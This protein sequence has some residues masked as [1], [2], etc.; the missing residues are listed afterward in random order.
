VRVPV[1]GSKKVVPDPPHAV[2]GCPGSQFGKRK[3]FTPRA[4]IGTAAPPVRLAEFDG[5][6]ASAIAVA[7]TV[8]AARLQMREKKAG[9][10]VF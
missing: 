8:S 7:L 9:R 2:P 5:L 1:T 4:M 10:F 6:K 3:G